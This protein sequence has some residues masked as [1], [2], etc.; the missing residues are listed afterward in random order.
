MASID[1][2][3]YEGAV[4]LRRAVEQAGFDLKDVLV[5]GTSIINETY[6]VVQTVVRD[7]QGNVVIHPGNYLRTRTHRIKLSDLE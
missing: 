1:D 3:R 2:I 4:R 7:D 6:L 5:A